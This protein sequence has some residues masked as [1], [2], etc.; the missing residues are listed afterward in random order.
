[1]VAFK[2]AQKTKQKLRLALA[3]PAGSGKTYTALALAAELAKGGNGRVAL[4]DT[5]HGSASLYADRVD[6]D[7]LELD[8][9]QPRHYID[10]LKAAGDAGYPV[11][12][13]DSFSHAW[14]GEGGILDQKD[15]MGG[16]FDA[17]R[18]LTPQHNELVEAILAYPGH[19][20]ATMRS[21]T[22]YVVEQTDGGKTKVEKKGMAPIQRDGVE[23]EF[24]V[25]GDMTLENTLIVSKSRC[26][27]IP[28][29]TTIRKPD[30]A[31][32][33]AL[34][35]WL[36]DGADA[37]PPAAKPEPKADP[38]PAPSAAKQ[39]VSDV[40]AI[41]GEAA[42]IAERKAKARSWGLGYLNRLD[43]AETLD[44]ALDLIESE[45]KARG[46][47]GDVDAKL[48][49]AI[50]AYE[51]RMFAAAGTECVELTPEDKAALTWLESIRA[52][53]EPQT[54]VAA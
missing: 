13:I 49:G 41:Q 2:K 28:P 29:G 40:K 20:I 4:V 53:S 42:Q 24:T 16:K 47:L 19:V 10:A 27:K 11:V 6:F 26:S 35:A 31:V 12:V 30:A 32:A 14:S 25:T 1:M 33:R 50:Y 37:P 7:T 48:A 3:G 5:E 21:K 8:T 38:K 43:A 22:E 52:T 34:L 54:E 15:A 39:A 9:F 36:E 18:R 45:H 44:A 17:W 51:Q 23:Y 46:A